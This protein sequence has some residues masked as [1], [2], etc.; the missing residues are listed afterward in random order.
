MATTA[1]LTHVKEESKTHLKEEMVV[2]PKEKSPKSLTNGTSEVEDDVRSRMKKYW[3]VYQPSLEAMM[4]SSHPQVLDQNE[5]NEILSYLPDFKGKRVLE[6][7]AGIGR[8]TT[9]LAQLASHVTAVDFMESYIDENKKI[10]ARFDNIK[11]LCADVTALDL[12]AG[13]FDLVFSNWLLMYLSDSE[14]QKLLSRVLQWLSPSGK[15]F[16]RESCYHPSGNIKKGSNP[17]F[18]R[19]PIEYLTM[20]QAVREEGVKVDN[21]TRSTFNLLRGKSILAYINYHGNPNQMCFLAEKTI[22]HDGDQCQERPDGGSGLA[23]FLDAEQFTFRSIFR[24][25]KIYGHTWISTGGERTTREFLTT[26][27]LTPGQRVLDVGCGTGGSAF[28]M[29]RHYGV[30]VHGVDLS[31]NM[32]QICIERQGKLEP[33]SKSKIQFEISDISQVEYEVESYDVIYSRDTILHIKDKKK[34]LEKVYR[35]LKPG[36]TLLISDYCS[37]DKTPSTDFLRYVKDRGYYLKTLEDTRTLL[38]ETGYEDIEAEDRTDQF[39]LTHKEDL[40]YFLP[41]RAA[42]VQEFSEQ[43]FNHLVNSWNAQLRRCEEGHLSW[44]LFRAKKKREENV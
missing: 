14:V 30:H 33:A 32:I 17:T 39:V 25:E 28:Y 21:G 4:L 35:W 37:T 27:G 19:T 11:Y 38:E 7:G 9:H 12:P 5:H 15:L 29:A 3:S 10:N 23:R 36:G 40:K 24:Y 6:L 1:V 20:L 16:I 2:A 43:D 31:T 13:S 41:T 8:Y 22:V 42:F 34:L 44:G 26:L 18:Y